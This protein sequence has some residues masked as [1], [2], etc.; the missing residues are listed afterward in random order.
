MKIAILGAG[1]MGSI[2]AAHLVRA[3]DDATLIARGSRAEEIKEKGI[4]IAGLED[5]NVPCPVVT[6]PETLEKADLL[7]YTVKTYDM[8]PAL[9]A[10][11]HM[12]VGSVFSVQNGVLKNE[13]MAAVY[14]QDKILGAAAFSSGELEQ[15]GLVRF[16]LNQCLSIGELSGGTSSR[17][18]RI[19]GILEDA[20]IKT[21]AS[22]QIQTVEWSKFISWLALMSLS[23][24]TRLNTWKFLSVPD[25]AKFGAQIMKET[26]LLAGKRG[27]DLEDRPPF[28]VKSMAG[29]SEEDAAEKL[30]EVGALMEAV[31]PN[32]RVSALQDLERGKRL[33][34]GETLG[35]V[36]SK[37]REE[38]IPVPAVEMALRLINGI[39][40]YLK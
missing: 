27:I 5:F 32:H 37:A 7:I 4:T 1:A 15:N 28:S 18:D 33:E 2:L 30:C 8:E 40:H 25:T 10:L 9:K 17:V 22:S 35:Y 11:G 6:E 13:Q 24:L 19:V 39:N 12:D 16:T 20:G 26:A 36:V 21:E 34:A 38:N 29:M 3:G 31:T 14:G 23:V